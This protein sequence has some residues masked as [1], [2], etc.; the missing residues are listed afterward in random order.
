MTNEL[1]VIN[2]LMEEMEVY[3]LGASQAPVLESKRDVRGSEGK[4]AL[5]YQL[6]NNSQCTVPIRQAGWPGGASLA[7][8]RNGLPAA[9]SEPVYLEP[10]FTSWW[11]F[12]RSSMNLR[13]NIS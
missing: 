13:N 12:N 6:V 4:K 5:M 1:T 9:D 8:H 11:S 3:F 2:L 7:R 10:A